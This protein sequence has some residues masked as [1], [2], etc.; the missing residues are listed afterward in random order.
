VWADGSIVEEHTLK[1][2][3]GL[4]SAGT[5][6]PVRGR[7]SSDA[8]DD[9]RAVLPRVGGLLNSSPERISL[10]QRASRKFHRGP[11]PDGR[12][13]FHVAGVSRIH[14]DAFV[15]GRLIAPAV[16][17]TSDTNWAAN[18]TLDIEADF[19]APT[20]VTIRSSSCGRMEPWSRSDACGLPAGTL[21]AAY[22]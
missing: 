13:V 1:A 6:S 3:D 8:D 15:I 21:S 2:F 5:S 17:E 11:P 10:C 22:G 19:Y 4:A 14:A 18:T 9:N 16:I 7:H 12:V 20:A